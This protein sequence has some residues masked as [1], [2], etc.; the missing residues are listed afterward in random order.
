MGS[1]VRP[2]I[3][4]AV[5]IS[6]HVLG[7]PRLHGRIVVWPGYY[8]LVRLRERELASFTTGLASP[9]YGYF[10]CKKYYNYMLSIQEIN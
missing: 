5:H 2:S 8:C 3:L 10:K 9:A 1:Q 4:D 6:R 7:W